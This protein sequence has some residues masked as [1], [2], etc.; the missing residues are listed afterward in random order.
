MNYKK[1][2]NYYQDCNFSKAQFNKKQLKLPN[3]KD[4]IKS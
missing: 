3:Y 4:K 1:E 2:R